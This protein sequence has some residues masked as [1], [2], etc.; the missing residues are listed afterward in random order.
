MVICFVSYDSI[1]AQICIV[2]INYVTYEPEKLIVSLS[3][4]A[5]FWTG[6]KTVSESRQNQFRTS[7]IIRTPLSYR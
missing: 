7:V 5:R 2:R 4:T 6:L 1:V 3:E